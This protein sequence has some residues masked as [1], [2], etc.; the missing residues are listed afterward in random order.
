M[1]RCYEHKNK[2]AALINLIMAEWTIKDGV[3]LQS[4][5]LKQTTRYFCNSRVDDTLFITSPRESK[6][7]Q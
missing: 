4:Q 3:C 7:T 2:A 6:E 5:T 1:L